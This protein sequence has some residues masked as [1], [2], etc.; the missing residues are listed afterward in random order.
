MFRTWLLCLLMIAGG[1]TALAAPL[2]TT[3]FSLGYNAIV[4]FCVFVMAGGIPS[5]TI[6]LAVSLLTCWLEGREGNSDFFGP[7]IVGLGTVL[8]TLAGVF[9]LILSSRVMDVLWHR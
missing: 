4:C 6:G 5:A 2:V 9:A 3:G 1:L 8:G 7:L